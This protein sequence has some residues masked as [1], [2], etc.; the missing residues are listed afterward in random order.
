MA[1]QLPQAPT[2]TLDRLQ[3]EGLVWYSAASR[4]AASASRYD[5]KN[6]QWMGRAAD[7]VVV[8]ISHD[9]ASAEEYLSTFPN[10]EQW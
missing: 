3:A 2:P 8:C 5:D 6:Y 7:G 4:D 9:A 10:P 1:T